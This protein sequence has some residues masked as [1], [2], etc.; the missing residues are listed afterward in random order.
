MSLEQIAEAFV[1]KATTQNAGQAAQPT[2]K[3]GQF[4]GTPYSLAKSV[5]GLAKAIEA[6]RKPKSASEAD[7]DADKIAGNSEEADA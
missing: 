3:N 1:P 4:G 6:K 5:G 7:S 2:P